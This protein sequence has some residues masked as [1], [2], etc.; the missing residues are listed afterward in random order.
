M[1][2]TPNL[3][4]TPSI[5]SARIT[6]ANTSSQGG[7]T[8]GTDIFLVESAGV[9]GSF[10]E[11]VRFSPTATAPTNTTATVARVF[12]SS[13]SSGATTNANT[14]LLGEVTLPL[15]AADNASAS[16]P[17]IDLPLNMNLPT[18]FHILV[19]THAAPAANTA[20]VATG[21]GGDY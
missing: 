15:V 1:A 12:Y 21:I 2:S 5:G 9:N 8:I 18:G 3:L 6:A 16:A 4:A 17:V 14:F 19:T 20:W 10:I 11:R 7:G 13:V